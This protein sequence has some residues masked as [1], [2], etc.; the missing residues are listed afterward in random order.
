[1]TTFL[2]LNFI[3]ILST[4]LTWA[5]I[6]RV[7]CSW[8]NVGS[9]IALYRLLFEVT[10]PLMAPIRR[11]MPSTMMIDLSPL[12]VLVILQVIMTTLVQM[13]VR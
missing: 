9:E 12:I 6:I 4:L 5:I 10:E 1:M 2:F 7:L 11:L 3:D 8:F 13:V